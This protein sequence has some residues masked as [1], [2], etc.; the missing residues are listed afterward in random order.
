MTE[1]SN[2]TVR[3]LI[4]AVQLEDVRLKESTAKTLVRD[5]ATVKSPTISMSHGAK[6]IHRFA[7]GFI[8]AAQLTA[9]VDSGDA[10]AT[11]ADAPIQMMVAFALVYR[12]ADAQK[13]SDAVLDEFAQTNAV[14]NAW[15]YWREYVQTTSARMNLPPMTLPVFRVSSTRDEEPRP[16]NSRAAVTRPRQS[17]RRARSARAKR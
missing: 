16:V 17:K 8:V 13:Y 10:A 1:L 11:T 15:P 14:F 12:L 2:R 3:D 9:R 4:A 7:D 6:V 5:L